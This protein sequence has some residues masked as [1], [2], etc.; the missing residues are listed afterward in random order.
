MPAHLKKFPQ[1]TAK[2]VRQEAEKIIKHDPVS[3]KQNE[4]THV[5]KCCV[6]VCV[7]VYSYLPGSHFMTGRGGKTKKEIYS[8]MSN[9]WPRKMSRWAEARKRLLD[10]AMRRMQVPFGREVSVEHLGKQQTLGMRS[11]GVVRRWCSWPLTMLWRK[12]DHVHTAG[13]AGER[14]AKTE[15]SYVWY[16]CVLCW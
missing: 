8:T 13:L 9:K 6:S 11:K 12:Q 5:Y 16:V 4:N 3:I 2:W 10:L 15:F 14:R 7:Y 1:W